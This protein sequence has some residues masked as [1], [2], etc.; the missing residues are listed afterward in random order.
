MA[1]ENPSPPSSSPSP[2]SSFLFKKG[3]EV[4]VTSPDPDLRGTLFPAKVV[5]QSSKKRRS[6]QV[7]YSHLVIPNTGDDRATKRL[8]EYL[9]LA[10]LRPSLPPEDAPSGRFERDDTVDAFVV[11]AWW[12]GTVKEVSKTGASCLVY[13]KTA[14]WKFWFAA[15]DLRLHREWIR[16]RWVPPFK[17]GDLGAAVPEPEGREEMGCTR[18]DLI[19][20]QETSTMI[21]ETP[22]NSK[23]PI[24]KS[25]NPFSSGA[26]VEVKTDE[27]GLEGSWYLAKILDEVGPGKFLIE[28]ETLTVENESTKKLVEE[29]LADQLRP[30]PPEAFAMERYTKNANVDAYVNDGWWEGRVVIVFNRMKYKVY[31]EHGND[32]MVVHHTFLR[33]HLEWSNG[34]WIM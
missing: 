28:Y 8:R 21:G 33:P 34:E 32:E 4:E 31:F 11:G 12:E 20:S 22:E 13:F 26:L 5:A 1:K 25:T 15:K 7:E 19:R 27:Q 14:G 9:P 3:S 17:Q 6:C 24:Q 30:R 2:S 23:S 16:G 18:D 10:L 29:V